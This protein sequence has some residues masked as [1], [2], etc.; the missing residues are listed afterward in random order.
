MVQRQEAAFQFLVAH[1][2]FAETI[3]PAV[4]DLNHP[5]SGP[6]AGVA[7]QFGGFLPA[8]LYVRNVAVLLDDAQRRCS[9]IA[10]VRTQMLA[11]THWRLRFF[12]HDRG[13]YSFQLRDVM[14]IGARDDE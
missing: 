7:F 6:L 5:S 3:E 11:S 14:P 8:P 12:D 9:G 1:Q 13:Q 4:G 10:C 2:Q